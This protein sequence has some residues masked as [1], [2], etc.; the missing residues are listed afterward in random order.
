LA[1]SLGYCSTELLSPV[2]KKK[3][4]VVDMLSALL[5][6]I[7][8]ERGKNSGNCDSDDS[9]TQLRVD[10]CDVLSLL[11]RK[12]LTLSTDSAL[13]LDESMKIVNDNDIS[14]SIDSP[15]RAVRLLP[16]SRNAVKEVSEKTVKDQRF[17][18]SIR[19]LRG[20]FRDSNV[21][22][23]NL[24]L[25]DQGNRYY[26]KSMQFLRALF[27]ESDGIDAQHDISNDM[28]FLF[29]QDVLKSIESLLQ[30]AVKKKIE[31][32]R[33]LLFTMFLR[34]LL[35]LELLPHDTLRFS[36][37]I[38]Q[39]GALMYHS[40]SRVRG[41]I[42][43]ALSSYFLDFIYE[44]ERIAITELLHILH[45]D[46]QHLPFFSYY[47]SWCRSTLQKFEIDIPEKKIMATIIQNRNKLALFSTLSFATKDDLK[48]QSEE[49]LIFLDLR[50]KEMTK[51]SLK[52]VN[53]NCDR[54][55]D[56]TLRSLYDHWKKLSLEHHLKLK[57]LYFFNSIS[58]D[59]IEKS[60]YWSLDSF[61]KLIRFCL[62]N[63]NMGS[64]LAPYFSDSHDFFY[65]IDFDLRFGILAT[66]LMNEK[67]KL[68]KGIDENRKEVDGLLSE[69]K[70]AGD[71]HMLGIYFIYFSQDKVI[72]FSKLPNYLKFLRKY[73]A[74][75]NSIEF[76]TYL[77]YVENFSQTGGLRDFSR[78]IL[79]LKCCIINELLG[80][81][82]EIA[83]SKNYSISLL[84][85]LQRPKNAK[86]K[87]KKTESN[88]TLSNFKMVLEFAAKFPHELGSKISL[89]GS[90][91]IF[92]EAFKILSFYNLP[93]SCIDRFVTALRHYE[94]ELP[95]VII[96]RMKDIA[97]K[98][99]FEE[100]EK[101]Y[102]VFQEFSR[103][104]PTLSRALIESTPKLPELIQNFGGK[105]LMRADISN[106]IETKRQ[107]FRNHNWGPE[108][109]NEV[110]EVMCAAALLTFNIVLHQSQV[111][112]CLVFL[113]KRFQSDGAPLKGLLF[114]VFT[115]EGKSIIIAIMAVIMVLHGY[116][117]DVVTSSPVLAKRDSIFFRDFFRLFGMN[118]A[119]NIDPVGYRDGEKDCYASQVVYGE[120]S[121]FQFDWLRT[122]YFHMKTQG[123]RD[124]DKRFLIIDEVDSVI[125]DDASKIA[126]LSNSLAGFDMLFPVYHL[127]WEKV[128]AEVECIFMDPSTRSQYYLR[129]GGFVQACNNDK[130]YFVNSR[131]QRAELGSEIYYLISQ[132]NGTQLYLEGLDKVRFP[133][134]EIIL[135]SELI[136]SK[137]SDPLFRKFILEAS[138]RFDDILS[139]TSLSPLIEVVGSYFRSLW[140]NQFVLSK[141]GISIKLEDELVFPQHLSSFLHLQ[142]PRYVE[143]ALIALHYTRDVHYIV[144][145]NKILPVDF[146]STGLVHESTH[147]GNGVHQF[148]QLKHNLALTIEGLP[149]NY[150]SNIGYIKTYKSHNLVGLTGTLGNEADVKTMAS[151]LYDV[152]LVYIPR[153]S[154]RK[155]ISFPPKVLS[156][157]S[158]W[159]EEVVN[160]AIY[161]TASHTGVLVICQSIED[162]AN[163][164]K[165]FRKVDYHG[166][167]KEY[168][169]SDK[170]DEYRLDCIQNGEIIIATNLAGRGMNLAASKSNGG[171][172]VILA[173]AP[174]NSRVEEQAIGRTSRGGKEGTSQ[175]I[176][177]LQVCKY[178]VRYS[179]SLCLIFR[180]R[181]SSLALNK[182][183]KLL[184]SL[185]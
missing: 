136:L 167:I 160:S 124:P 56:D 85:I 20:L 121:Q 39:L 112:A 181:T 133:V 131:T 68:L 41:I 11:K 158:D 5:H 19:V 169:I 45:E 54:D 90:S 128:L 139:A 69:A 166:V 32:E 144:R 153:Q 94:R 17:E 123:K 64:I 102:S 172:H 29:S 23:E 37:I 30:L 40:N 47:F 100:L 179:I 9:L 3:K 147:W 35:F 77:Q 180:I 149:T 83:L 14:K 38:P 104:N 66:V 176:T 113:K 21:G 99:H 184:R 151:D 78:F 127:I 168:I 162:A 24:S 50:A 107:G 118:G 31:G 49:N 97:M 25:L 70:K 44:N 59:G 185:N 57:L 10:I 33:L 27:V 46:R 115:G 146:Q 18:K 88:S 98:L 92:I 96:A 122:E 111:L 79:S 22:L 117:V 164:K 2:T 114:Q 148:L 52:K 80:N 43:Q 74:D 81:D 87:K 145:A 134:K 13:L 103:D 120:I 8:I 72:L 140:Q 1:Y 175:K 155:H 63:E 108:F 129:H 26:E 4:S 141:T 125:I 82:R 53:P 12:G 130:I 159:L 142:Y 61:L 137:V 73:A 42:F 138:V 101:V 105:S 170:Y 152:S 174:A 182:N 106:F 135:T 93:S 6:Y 67:I 163:L 34:K 171:F 58:I 76:V 132:E 36:T 7:R 48:S 51:A 173:Y 95:N 177:F 16:G 119:H 91:N 110:M 156:S 65:E 84:Y 62:I 178:F 161:E 86:P 75:L 126:R 109:L 28:E 89:G 157:Y 150:I 183:E 154:V 143:S 55:C 165:K 60:E 116:V 71:A 15:Q